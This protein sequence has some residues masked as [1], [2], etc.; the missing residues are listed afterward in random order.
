MTHNL[1]PCVHVPAGHLEADYFKR[2]LNIARSVLQSSEGTDSSSSNTQ[3]LPLAIGVGFLGWRLDES[4]GKT[5]KLLSIALD[6]RVAAVWFAFGN[7]LGKWVRHVRSIDANR[8]SPHKTIVFVLVNSLKEAKV[9][10]NDL[11]ADVLVAQGP[12]R[13]DFTIHCKSPN[14][15]HCLTS[16]F[17]GIEA[18]GH[19]SGE[20]PPLLDLVPEIIKTFTRGLRVGVPESQGESKSV[21]PPVIG[22]G[23]LTT[24]AQIAALLTLGA[25]GVALGTR[26]LLTPESL[27]PP[28]SKTALLAADATSTVRTTVFDDIRGTTGWPASID[29]RALRNTALE[30]VERGEKLE[31]VRQYVEKATREGDA[32]G[33]V[34][35][36]GTGIGLVTEIKS[37]GMSS[38]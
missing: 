7:D 15:F 14:V 5:A 9:A 13:F 3:I 18:G 6:A 4:D 23:G 10:V 12:Y 24:G 27:Y 8:S 38:S 37:A 1:P 11:C 30:R 36:A 26:F 25:S 20:A 17:S 34:V 19:S 2:E 28:A 29:G 35:W 21:C 22:A 32:A 16:H 31:D 33:M